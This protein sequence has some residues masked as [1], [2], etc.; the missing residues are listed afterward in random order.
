VILLVAVL[1][2]TVVLV[3]AACWLYG[4]VRGP[5]PSKEVVWAERYDIE[6]TPGSR[7]WVAAYLRSGRDL[8]QIGGFGGLIIATSISAATGIDLHVSGLVWILIGY[9]VG[10][11]WAELALTRAPSGTQ[12]VASLTTRRVADYLP[13]HIRLAQLV[14]PAATVGLGGLC[15]LALRAARLDSARVLASADSTTPGL[16]SITPHSTE[17]LLQSGALAAAIIAPLIMV[18]VWS[19]QRSVVSRPQPWLD[20]DLVAADDALRS[21]SVHRLGASSLA[22]VS[23]LIASQFGYLTTVT[24]EFWLDVSRIGAVIAFLSA[25]VIFRRWSDAPW[26]V[27]RQ[28]L[29]PAGSASPI[30]PDCGPM[31]GAPLGVP[32][33]GPPSA[34]TTLASPSIVTTRRSTVAADDG[35]TWTVRRGPVPLA[36]AIVIAMALA[37]WGLRTWGVAN[38][39]VNVTTS[40]SNEFPEHV[41]RWEATMFIYNEARAPIT[42]VAVDTRTLMATDHEQADTLP[43]VERVTAAPPSNPLGSPTA[44]SSESPLPVTVAGG[45]TASL[46]VDLL[47]PGCEAPS[48]L[49]PFQLT[50]SY[51]TQAGRS[52]TANVPPTGAQQVGQCGTALPTGPQPTDPATAEQAVRIAFTAAYDPNGVDRIGFVDDPTGV[53]ETTAVVFAGPFG[54]AARSTSAAIDAVSFDRPDHAWVRYQLSGVAGERMGEVSLSHGEWKVARATVCSDLALAGATCPP[55]P[56]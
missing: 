14:L 45:T 54:F 30:D 26:R 23:L 16:V 21:S 34:T 9:L 24:A 35:A 25:I 49:T 19:A 4:R 20:A 42:V 41:S 44:D 43:V 27:Q 40:F 8:R 36:V 18:V 56:N 50:V 29:I 39:A 32:S 22:A 13:R 11:V 33:W 1:L 28:S 52:A 37:G 51:R 31:N 6:L 38:P 5:G 3:L 47:A 53:A 15:V 46:T 12:R 2:G 7:Q 55:K 10:C 48:T 17:Q